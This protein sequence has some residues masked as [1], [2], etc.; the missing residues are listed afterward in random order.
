MPRILC[1]G[2]SNTWGWATVSYPDDRYPAAARWTGVMVDALGA[3]WDLIEEG[4][5]GRTTVHDDPIEG[6]H[7]N[8]A[9]YLLPCLRS[10]RPLDYVVIMLGT[11]DLKARFAV[12][13]SDIAKG[14]G[15]LLEI[16]R[17]AGAGRDGG[18]PKVLVICPPPLLDHT[19][20]FAD[21][22]DMLAGGYAKSL[23]M[24]PHFA[25]MARAGGAAFLDAGK[26]IVTSPFDGIH[27]DVEEQAKL[28]RAIAVA[29]AKL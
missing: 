9:T 21:Y 5:P 28:G 22:A 10:H 15:K 26:H 13:P 2:D 8:G 4:L 18:T 16:V 19:G 24:A 6:A 1:Y 3:G 27:L 25:E 17:G 11:N 20:Q 14:A 7:M 23:K 29:V 12:Q